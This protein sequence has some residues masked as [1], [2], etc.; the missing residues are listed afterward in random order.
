MTV[1]HSKNVNE[2]SKQDVAKHKAQKGCAWHI[3]GTQHVLV[4]QDEYT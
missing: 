1:G 3:V 4:P 2:I